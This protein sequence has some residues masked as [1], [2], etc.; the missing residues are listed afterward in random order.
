MRLVTM[1]IVGSLLGTHLSGMTI[2]AVVSGSVANL[3]PTAVIIDVSGMVCA[4]CASSIEEKFKEVKG[5]QNIFVDLKAR[6]VI[7]GFEGAP[8]LSDKEMNALILDAGYA[9]KQ[10]L[11]SEESFADLKKKYAQGF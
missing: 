10:I 8:T 1:G 2:P 3:A 6:V 4:F 5:V 11:R 9:P 7:V